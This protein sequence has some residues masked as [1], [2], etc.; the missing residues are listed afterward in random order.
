MGD[1]NDCS[2]F[3]SE[4]RS[5]SCVIVSD[6]FSKLNKTTT[7]ITNVFCSMFDDSRWR[8]GILPII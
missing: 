4:F 5:A 7:G 3:V 1:M 2:N 6:A 8:C